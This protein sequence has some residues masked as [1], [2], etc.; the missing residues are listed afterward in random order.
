[1][2]DKVRVK[3]SFKKGDGEIVAVFRK[4]WDGEKGK[5][6]EPSNGNVSFVPAYV[7]FGQHV[8]IY[9]SWERG[10]RT[11]K[12]EEYAGLLSELQSIGYEV[13]DVTHR[14]KAA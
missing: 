7:H 11:A 12:T 4:E 6:V 8:Q 1:M 10:L 3:V 5:W 9:R 13:V 2:Q 14:R